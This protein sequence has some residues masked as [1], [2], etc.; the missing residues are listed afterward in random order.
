MCWKACIHLPIHD[1]DCTLLDILWINIRR[2]GLGVAFQQLF[3]LTS[4][5]PCP[6]GPAPH[7]DG[8][9]ISAFRHS[10]INSRRR[11][12]PHISCEFAAK[13]NAGRSAEEATVL[14]RISAKPRFVGNWRPQTE[15]TSPEQLEVIEQTTYV[16]GLAEPQAKKTMTGY[17]SYHFSFDCSL[18]RHHNSL[19]KLVVTI[20]RRKFQENANVSRRAFLL[21]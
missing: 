11:F 16:E 15:K 10:T 19:W 20:M 18:S 2:L 17:T 4:R 5:L 13:K 21:L 6:D 1:D 14:S 8:M 9:R 7:L 12:F 3:Q